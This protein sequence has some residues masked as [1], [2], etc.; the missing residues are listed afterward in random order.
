MRY[1]TGMADSEIEVQGKQRQRRRLLLT[2]SQELHLITMIAAGLKQA[3]INMRAAEFNPPYVVTASQ[4]AWMEK[5]Y[6]LTPRDV[7][8]KLESDAMRTGLALR[9]ERV[10]ALKKLAKR[11]MADL[12][13]SLWVE[14]EK[15]VGLTPVITRYFN[16]AEIEQFRGVLDDIARE[17]G[18]RKIRSEVELKP[19]IQIDVIMDSLQRVYGSND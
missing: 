10:E 15:V 18:D 19:V 3:E 7:S 16:R 8:D 14:T 17:V 6:K 9:A 2:Q 12:D 1:D 13:V 5:K 4:R 11:M